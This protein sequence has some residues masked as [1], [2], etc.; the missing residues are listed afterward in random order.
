[1]RRLL[2]LALCFLIALILLAPI[3]PHMGDQLIYPAHN[4]FSDLTITHWPAFAYARDQIAATGQVPMW[5]TSILSGTPFSSDPS[6]GM[7]YPPHWLALMLPLPIAFN[8]LMLLHLA[9]AAAS[10][11]LLMRRW[12]LNTTAAIASAIAYAAAPKIIAH[13]GVGH[14][15]LV[16]AW[17]WLPLV[18]AGVHSLKTGSLELPRA[19]IWPL[20]S[21]LALALCLLAD[22]RMAIYAA[23]L[24]ITYLLV[25]HLHR[26]RSAWL[27][28]I[29]PII[30]LIVIAAAVST[31]SW[32]PALTLT[33]ST[34]RASITPEEAGTQSLDPIYLL[35]VIIADRSGAAER[36]TY[37]GLV[38]LILAIVGAKLFYRRERRRV[39]WLIGVL[40]VGIIA[41][42]GL[43]TPLY[44]ILLALPGSTLLRVPARAWFVVTFAAAALAGLGV[45][46]LIEWSGAAKGRSIF[47]LIL[48]A[49]AALLFGAIGAF[50]SGSISFAAIALW[51]PLTC[52][53]LIL[54]LTR[55]LSPARFSILIV[56]LIS[57][58]L[59]T[60]DWSLYRS[61]PI[62][63]AFADGRAAAEWIANQ[64]GSARVYSSSYSIPQQVAQQYHLQL[65]DGINPLQLA[66]TV[67]FMQ[68]ATGVGAWNYSVT[69]PAFPN[70]KQ[71]ADIRSALA[72][73][74][75][76]VELLGLL[77]VKYIVS[78]FPIEH[79]DLIERAHLAST[80]IYENVR[81][82]PR[83]FVM[84]HIES[85]PDAKAAAEWLATHEVSEAA[86][87]EGLAQPIDLNITP[88]EAP[89]VSAQPDR[90]EVKTS[91]PG[92]LV[93]SE[94]YAPDW[95]ATVDD[96]LAEIFPTDLALRGVVLPTGDHTIVFTY[97]PTRVYAGA[98][99]SILSLLACSVAIGVRKFGRR[100]HG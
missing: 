55:K 15:T 64:S 10:M 94:V 63:Q 38:V 61:I 26:T 98:F 77:N 11:Y 20:A 96:Q 37:V 17:A 86:V 59:I 79:I 23:F 4:E 52:L 9:L 42:L 68:Q 60:I 70:L 45:Q 78:A 30:V 7:F 27:K 32:L 41:A 19:G 24:A 92:L 35:G 58:D 90:I 93:L 65:A 48:V 84:T 33:G 57:I 91:G 12:N 50:K 29:A 71:D 18:I 2:P 22:A 66:R 43:N 31:V 97:Q 87:V 53:L 34:A 67:T 99:I 6:S 3:V 89:I 46:G 54:R 40:I 49:L 14:V 56:A 25:Q 80:Y 76:D 74:T 95:I 72:N 85:V 28:T 47:V 39:I 62:D 51:L 81:V 16:E 83:A 82:M 100:L 88:H 21:G 44:R 73:V 75:P 36:T 13:M 8:L 5:R 69:L 1:M